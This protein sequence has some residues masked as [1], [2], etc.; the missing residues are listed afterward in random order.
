ML[1]VRTFL[2][3]SE[4]IQ[5][6]N[7]I[8]L[9]LHFLN[10]WMNIQNFQVKFIETIQVR[11]CNSYFHYFSLDVEMDLKMLTNFWTKAGYKY[12]CSKYY[13]KEWPYKSQVLMSRSRLWFMP[14]NITT[15][16][17]I[18]C[19]YNYKSSNDRNFK[20]YFLYFNVFITS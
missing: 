3:F 12:V 13:M 11:K 10:E 9:I 1:Q 14:N 7:M 2:S 15:E 6:W 4:F 16:K 19:L 18:F 20:E 8:G 5:F 17:K